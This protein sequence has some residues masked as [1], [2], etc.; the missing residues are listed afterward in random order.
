MIRNKLFP[1]LALALFT[2]ATLLTGRAQTFPLPTPTRPISFPLQRPAITG[3]VVAWGSNGAGQT[4]VPAGNNFVAIAASQLATIALRSDGTVSSWGLDNLIR[5]V[6]AGLS[7][8]VAIAGGNLHSVALKQ[9]GTVV[10]WG[11]SSSDGSTNVPN[12]LSGVLA[13]A[14]SYTNYVNRVV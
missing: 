8:V 13:I 4:P 14:A 2:F 11:S 9:D 1:A 6:P 5:P 7:N 12:G 3:T 10:A